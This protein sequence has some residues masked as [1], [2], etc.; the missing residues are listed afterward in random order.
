MIVVL[1]T[2]VGCGGQKDA[3][4]YEVDA[5]DELS[6]TADAFNATIDLL[7]ETED[8]PS[9]W[10]NDTWVGDVQG[11]LNI[12]RA[13]H[14]RLD[15]LNPSDEFRDAHTSVLQFS[16][17]N[18]DF[19]DALDDQLALPS[20]VWMTINELAADCVELSEIAMSAFERVVMADELATRAAL[21]TPTN[22]SQDGAYHL[23]RLMRELMTGNEEGESPPR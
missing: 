15:G 22:R 4:A 2:T 9:L 6:S 8:C 19:A 21:P 18:S 3:D 10:S 17:C 1:L 5:A 7:G 13:S 11:Q 16:E 20:P 12:M 23:S 14:D